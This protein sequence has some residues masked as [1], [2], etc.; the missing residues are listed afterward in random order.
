MLRHYPNSEIEV[1]VQ[2]LQSDG[3]ALPAAINAA[4][5]ALIDAGV[6]MRD[7]VVGCS[8]AYIQRTPLLGEYACTMLAVGHRVAPR[9]GA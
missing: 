3:G 6:A 7:F 8:V 9:E 4:T 1:H 5:L 2:V